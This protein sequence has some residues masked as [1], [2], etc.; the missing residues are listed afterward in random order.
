MAAS[1]LQPRAAG[2]KTEWRKVAQREGPRP[3]LPRVHGRRGGLS[4]VVR[5]DRGAA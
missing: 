2:F 4:E 1:S 5:V 3:A